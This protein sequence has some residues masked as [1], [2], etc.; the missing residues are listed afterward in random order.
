MIL[1]LAGHFAAEGLPARPLGPTAAQ[2]AHAAEAYRDAM[3]PGRL[4]LFDIG[5]LDSLGLSVYVAGFCGDSGL[6]FDG[7]GYG[8]GPDEALVGA[9]GELSETAHLEAALR[10]AAVEIASSAEMTARHGVDRVLDPL[11][12]CLPAGSD[13]APT[14]RLAWIGV[15]RWPDSA[16]GF[17]PLES[18]A[19]TPGQWRAHGEGRARMLFRP[20]T[21]GLGAGLSLERALVH[22]LLELLQRDG[23]CTT[24]RA[25]DRGVVIDIDRPVDPGLRS[26]LDDLAAKGLPLLPKLA[27]TEFGLANVYVVGQGPET[28]FPMAQTACGEAADI[29]A[30]RALRKAVLEFAAARCRKRF[31]HGPLETVERVAPNGYLLDYLALLDLDAEEPRALAEMSRWLDLDEAALIKG[32]ADTVF[33]ERARVPLSTLPGAVGAGASDPPARLAD[34]AARLDGAGMSVWYF[35][36]SPASAGAPRV[37]K[38]VVPGLEGE[39]MSYHRLGARGASRL[40]ERDVGFVGAAARPGWRQV[41]LTRQAE[42]GL[43]GPVWLDPRAVDAIVGRAYPLYREPSTHAVQLARRQGHPAIRAG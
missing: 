34:V 38:A 6:V 7:F 37:V 20:I 12:L 5:P 29:D 4:R 3:P 25:M 24:F 42:A 41:R 43:G 16:T 40:L 26:L 35:D 32:L 15:R 28:G 31:M 27:S 36:A 23:N 8:A 21:C 17:A 2:L 30:E 18:I 9:L 13:Y 1:G 39:T 19:A 33:A 10:G 14:D 22:G 11:T